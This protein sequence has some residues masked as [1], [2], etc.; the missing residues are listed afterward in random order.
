MEES[1]PMTYS[2]KSF[3]IAARNSSNFTLDGNDIENIQLGGSSEIN[4]ERNASK[5][6]NL[7]SNNTTAIKRKSETKLLASKFKG[8]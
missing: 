7:G 6:N 3:S 4:K 8:I 2:R 1:K 5:I